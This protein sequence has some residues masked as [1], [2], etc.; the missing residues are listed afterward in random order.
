MRIDS[1][2]AQLRGAQ[3]PQVNGDKI[4]G[5]KVEGNCRPQNVKNTDT[6]APHS[7]LLMLKMTAILVRM[8]RGIWHQKGLGHSLLDLE[9]D[10]TTNIKQT[11]R[12]EH[13]RQWMTCP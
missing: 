11:Q 5:T 10:A 3:K 8:S 13:T 9:A 6:L 2:E 7:S 12:E 1:I 4:A